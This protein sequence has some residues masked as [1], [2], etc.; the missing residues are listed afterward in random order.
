M[1]TLTIIEHNGTTHQVKADIGQSVM[2]A[3][4]FGGVPGI[5]ADCGGACACA[6]CHGYVD[7][8]WMARVGA[9]EG[10]EK[11]MLDNVPELRPNSRLSC[12]LV[13]SAEMDGF[14]MRLPASQY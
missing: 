9:A 11:D 12:Q 6:T 5:P 14:T 1:P 3:A 13:V 2:Q 7:D 10:T 4:T 8:A